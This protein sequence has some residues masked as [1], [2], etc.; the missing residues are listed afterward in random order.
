MTPAQA[1]AITGSGCWA[2]LS[3]DQ[4]QAAVAAMIGQISG[5]SSALATTSPGGLRTATAVS[6]ANSNRRN[7]ILQNQKAELLYVKFGT[8]ATTSDY[9]FI[10]TNQYSNLSFAGYEGAISVAPASG[11]PSYTFSEFVNA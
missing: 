10:L 6:A 8:G 3:P 5:A 2:G 1:N 11:S 9:H 7:F 4:L